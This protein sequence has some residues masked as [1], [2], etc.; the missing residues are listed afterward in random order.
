MIWGLKLSNFKIGGS[1]LQNI[2]NRG[3]NT[4]IKPFLF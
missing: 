1:N 3:T 4:A 2:E